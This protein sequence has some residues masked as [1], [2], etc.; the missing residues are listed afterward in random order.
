MNLFRLVLTLKPQCNSK[1]EET[2]VAMRQ[3]LDNTGE[4][5]EKIS[6]EGQSVKG[7]K[8][9]NTFNGTQSCFRNKSSEI[10]H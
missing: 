7:D 5:K 2:L 1:N 4:G 3:T 10:A 6:R 8:L 9:P